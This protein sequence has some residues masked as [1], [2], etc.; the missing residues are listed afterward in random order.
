MK[1]ALTILTLALTFLLVP[2]LYK[3]YA[4]GDPLNWGDSVPP[5]IPA[6]YDSYIF[7]SSSYGYNYYCWDSTKISAT[8][9]RLGSGSTATYWT[10][11]KLSSDNSVQG[12]QYWKSSKTGAWESAVT[13]G[14]SIY[15][16]SNYFETNTNLYDSTGTTILAQKPKT[17][18]EILQD[19]QNTVT[20]YAFTG[21]KIYPI[22]NKTY[23]DS[24]KEFKV[25]FNI[26]HALIWGMNGPAIGRNVN[27]V[28]DKI[29][30]TMK[31]TI[32]DSLVTPINY[33]INWDSQTNSIYKGYI[34]IILP[35]QD[36]SNVIKFGAE[37]L[38]KF[39]TW[40]SK[41]ETTIYSDTITLTF[42]LPTDTNNDGIDDVT[43][44]PIEQNTPTNGIP[45]RSNYVEGVS[46]DLNYYFDLIGYWITSPFRFISNTL[47]YVLTELA[48]MK[49]DL[50]NGSNFANQI[51]VYVPTA[52]LNIIWGGIGITILFKILGR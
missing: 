45:Q 52:L 43:G 7:T 27:L 41:D 25:Y 50:I 13:N 16:G 14:N 11:Y 9:P 46:G 30:D 17:P 3:A 34:S 15:S 35:M 23:Y 49:T 12:M 22:E 20:S 48:L 31:I 2:S 21:V 51:F 6:G 39:G 1:K 28:K 4:V 36:G 37:F 38:T 33:S 10:S 44:L 8:Y 5:N 19:N 32:N 18:A 26:P 40:F 24:T 29:R 42:K 47:K